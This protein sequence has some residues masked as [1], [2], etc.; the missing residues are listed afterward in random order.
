MTV[1]LVGG[2]GTKY[3]RQALNTHSLEQ[4]EVCIKKQWSFPLSEVYYITM[5]FFNRETWMKRSSLELKG[6]KKDE[7]LMLLALLSES[8]YYAITLLPF[9]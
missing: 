6:E 3:N 9:L 4:K 1:E 2:G 5:Q 7:G 8:S